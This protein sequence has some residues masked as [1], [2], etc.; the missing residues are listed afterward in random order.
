[1]AERITYE[2]DKAEFTMHAKGWIESL[3][4]K[5]VTLFYQSNVSVSINI[6]KITEVKINEESNVN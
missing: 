4:C 5:I 1:M 3:R 6:N 2:F